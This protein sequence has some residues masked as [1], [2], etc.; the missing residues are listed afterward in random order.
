MD[1]LFEIEKK[2]CYTRTYL[3][4]PDVTGYE[5]VKVIAECKDS[6]EYPEDGAFT[7]DLFLEISNYAIR[8]HLVGVGFGKTGMT[9]EEIEEEIF[10]FVFLMIVDGDLFMYCQQYMKDIDRLE[11]RE[12]LEG[13]RR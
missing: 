13:E 6:P 2:N 1:N 8:E 9:K 7:L 5:D 11:Q 4:N 3:I 12:N 10:P